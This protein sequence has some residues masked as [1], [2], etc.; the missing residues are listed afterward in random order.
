M[1]AL[2][3]VFILV[4]GLLFLAPAVAKGQNQETLYHWV[5][6][7]VGTLDKH[8]MYAVSKV[9]IAT[10]GDYDLKEEAF[11][12]FVRLNTDEKFVAE[13]PSACHD[14]ILESKAEKWLKRKLKSAKK[15]DFQILW[16]NF[17][18]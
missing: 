10:G 14:F 8:H 11:E 5:C 12:E 7:Q 3:K 17:S 13:F 18:Y 9:F 1:K 16:I 6:T 15:R 4:F 2:H